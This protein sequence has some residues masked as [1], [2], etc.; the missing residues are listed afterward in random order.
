MLNAVQQPSSGSPV[1]R[2]HTQPP[3]DAVAK[4][5][6]VQNLEEEFASAP[7]KTKAAS[8]T[9]ASAKSDGGQ[10]TSKK[11]KVGGIKVSDELERI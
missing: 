4:R 10:G 6:P 9:A 2:H 1:H 11:V 5:P 7:K 8:S 3:V